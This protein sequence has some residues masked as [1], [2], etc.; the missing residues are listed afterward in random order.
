MNNAETKKRLTNTSLEKLNSFQKGYSTTKPPV[1]KGF[2]EIPG[3]GNG[4]FIQNKEDQSIFKWIN[5]DNLIC[6]GIFYPKKSS[7][8]I[9]SKGGR[10]NFGGDI[11]PN[12]LKTEYKETDDS[13][14]KQCIETFGGFYIAITRARR[15]SLG[16]LTFSEGSL[17]DLITYPEAQKS[18]Q[19]YMK[20]HDEEFVSSLPCGAAIDCIFEE[21]FERFRFEVQRIRKE[22]ELEYDAWNRYEKEVRKQLQIHGIYGLE[23]LICSGSGEY[24]SEIFESFTMIATRCSGANGLYLIA[25][26]NRQKQNILNV[27]FPAAARNF[28]TSFECYDRGYRVM[29]LPVKKRI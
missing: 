18:A 21:I 19:N 15:N 16:K 26:S 17:I 23:D 12:D 1:F 3:N 4:F 9:R 11:F 7:K 8:T 27:S 5:V 20:G 22:D 25:D 10:R 13:N 6:N 24:T 29:L 28:T 14:F 2:T